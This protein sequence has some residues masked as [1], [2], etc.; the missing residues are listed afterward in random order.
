MQTKLTKTHRVLLLAACL[1]I[2]M[3]PTMLPAT[4]NPLNT[5]MKESAPI[6]TESTIRATKAHMVSMVSTVDNATIYYTTDG[7]KP[8]ATSKEY[9]PMLGVKVMGPITVK[10]IAVAPGRTDSAVSTV[11]F[12][13]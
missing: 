6:V 3:I 12:A 7:T 5:K 9:N 13:K 8:N 11:T 1:I 2:L 4:Q 10:A